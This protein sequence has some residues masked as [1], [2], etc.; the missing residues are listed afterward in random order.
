[1]HTN[2]NQLQETSVIL[3]MEA[4]N[5]LATLSNR[6]NGFMANRARNLFYKDLNTL[7]V[8]MAIGNQDLVD[9]FFITRYLTRLSQ[10]NEIQNI[11]STEYLAKILS[12]YSEKLKEEGSQQI[13]SKYRMNNDLL[14]VAVRFGSRIKGFNE[15]FIE[16]IKNDP[17]M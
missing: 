9:F 16:K 7:V 17:Q 1:M 4:C 15:M 11:I 10:S 12:F 5:N 8:D 14:S 3:C 6:Y 2:Q 13:I